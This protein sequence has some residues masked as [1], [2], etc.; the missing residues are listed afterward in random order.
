MQY[1]R[2]LSDFLSAAADECVGAARLDVAVDLEA[3]EV[4]GV[5]VDAEAELGP[6]SVVG[7]DDM[8]PVVL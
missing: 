5:E 8:P 2:A 4:G 3:A 6:L 7:A 1:R